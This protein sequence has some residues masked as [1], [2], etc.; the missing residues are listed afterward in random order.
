MGIHKAA[1][2]KDGPRRRRKAVKEWLTANATTWTTLI[3]LIVL[4]LVNAFTKWVAA[5]KRRYFE[6]GKVF[7]FIWTDVGPKFLGYVALLALV[8]AI[9]YLPGFPAAAATVAAAAV[10]GVYLYLALSLFGSV[11][12]NLRE[13]G[14]P[15]ADT[16]AEK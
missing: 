1:A 2:S 10:T 13:L 14:L 4:I 8:M 12:A 3:I 11:V 16:N 9:D 6:W 5:L 15:I 7:E